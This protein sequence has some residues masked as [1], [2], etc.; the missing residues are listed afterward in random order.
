MPALINIVKPNTP[1]SSFSLVTIAS[2]SDSL[3]DPDVA[4][5]IVLITESPVCNI[6]HITLERFPMRPTAIIS[7]INT[8]DRL[9]TVIC[10]LDAIS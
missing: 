3:I 1:S 4:V 6:A 8:F 2:T 10:S 9:S 5:V 7:V